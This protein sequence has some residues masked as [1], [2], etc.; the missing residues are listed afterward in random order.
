MTREAVENAARLWLVAAGA[1]GGVPNA[2]RAVIFADQDGPRPPLPYVTL[3]IETFDLPVGE[4]EDRVDDSD[5]P[6][7]RGRGN[8]RGSI[9]VNAFGA[10]A[11]DWLERAHL[12]LRAPSVKAQLTAA[13]IGV[14]PLGAPNNLSRLLDDKSQ[15]RFQRDFAIDYVAEVSEAEAE[16]VV[17]LEQV[18]HTDTFE[19][20]A[21]DL[22][23]TLTE[24]L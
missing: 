8:R 12:F 1:A 5:P 16:G 13:G 17:E 14:R 18:V 22:E 4:D 21:T 9:S 2:S 10:G 7:W 3:R 20:G 24:V 15:T 23:L 11:A 19:G 6:T